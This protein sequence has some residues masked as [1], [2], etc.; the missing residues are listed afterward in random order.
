MGSIEITVQTHFKT[1]FNTSK[2]LKIVFLAIIALFS[3]SSDNG[4]IMELFSSDKS[5]ENFSPKSTSEN[6]GEIRRTL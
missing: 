3:T 2:I 4:K 1:T 5:I 6:T